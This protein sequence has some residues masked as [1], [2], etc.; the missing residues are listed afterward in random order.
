MKKCLISLHSGSFIYGNIE[1]DIKQN[2]LIE[3]IIHFKI[4]SLDFPKNNFEET[5]KYLETQLIKYSKQYEIYL[6]GRC[7]GGYLAKQLFNR[8][9][10]LIKK[11]VYL[12]P[13]FRPKK[14][15]AINPEFKSRQD[16]YFRFS[17][18]IPATNQFDEKK[19]FI[20]LA[21]EDKNVPI[22]CFTKQQQKHIIFFNKTHRGLLFSTNINFINTI[23]K[24]LLAQ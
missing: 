11:V 12:A 3:E 21:K 8:H 4:I 5:I 1:Q 22:E 14:R 10:N 23:C 13:V 16:Y 7:S 20:F 24:I 2:S 9:P 18:P 19:E 15:E 6:I 17:N